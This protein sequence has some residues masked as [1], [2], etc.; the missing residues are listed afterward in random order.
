MYYKETQF[1]SSFKFDNSLSNSQCIFSNFIL[2]SKEE[3]SIH[4]DSWKSPICP[5]LN[6]LLYTLQ[7]LQIFPQLHLT[8]TLNLSTYLSLSSIYLNRMSVELKQVT[9]EG[10][11]CQMWGYCSQ[12]SLFPSWIIQSLFFLLCAF[13]RIQK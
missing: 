7:S 5:I 6:L 2:C 1:P 12:T 4:L 3:K 13:D 9:N 11:W 8:I 10:L